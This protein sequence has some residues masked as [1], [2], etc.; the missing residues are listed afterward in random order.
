MINYLQP[1]VKLQLHR[2]R[3]SPKQWCQC[4][5]DDNFMLRGVALVVIRELMKV[6]NISSAFATVIVNLFSVCYALMK[7]I[8]VSVAKIFFSITS[9]LLTHH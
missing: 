4:V 9:A 8:T 5:L 2:D 1:K 6:C 3:R 7:L